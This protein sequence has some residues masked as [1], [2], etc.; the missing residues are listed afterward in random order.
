M[1]EVQGKRL[2]GYSR[3]DGTHWYWG[4]EEVAVINETRRE[5]EWRNRT[6][7]FPNEVVEAVRSKMPQNPGIWIIEARRTRSSETQGNV[8]IFLN[9]KDMGMNFADEMILVD[10]KWVST[11]PDEE[12]GRFVYACLWHKLDNT[13]HYSDRFKDVFKP[14]WK[15]D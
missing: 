11:T 12:L 15:N 9:G 10:G 5:I 6:F 8:H 3:A 2:I 7:H 13:L 14:D 1:Q 4:N